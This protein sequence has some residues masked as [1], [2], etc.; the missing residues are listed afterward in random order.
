MV[1]WGLGWQNFRLKKILKK[2]KYSDINL[3]KG[4]ATFL[5]FFHK[6]IILLVLPFEELSI[7][8]ELSSP[9]CFRIQGGALSVTN[10][11]PMKILVSNRYGYGYRYVTKICNK[12]IFPPSGKEAGCQFIIYWLYVH[13]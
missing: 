2:K 11:W 13:I 3:K 8:P 4:N 10:R 7:R 9:P 5:P 1:G 12:A 6:K